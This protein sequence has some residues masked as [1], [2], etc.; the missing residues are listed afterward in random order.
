MRS[1]S[2]EAK[3]GLCQDVMPHQ[4]QWNLKKQRSELFWTNPRPLT[5][6]YGRLQ[7]NE[8]PDSQKQLYDGFGTYAFDKEERCW[9]LHKAFGALKDP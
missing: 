5:N 8:F 1:R 9:L 2:F 7:S 3:I 4:V 6:T